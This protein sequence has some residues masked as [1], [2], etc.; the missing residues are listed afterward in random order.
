[1]LRIAAETGT[2]DIVATPHANHTYAFR[3]ELIRERIEELRKLAPEGLKLHT[4]CD[5]H[6]RF[7]NIED[8]LQHP[9]RYTIN[10]RGYLMVEL[11]DSVIPP[12]MGQV[13]ERMLEK[14]IRPVITH[15]ERVP[16]LL[17]DPALLEPWIAQGCSVQITAQSLEGRFG[18]RASDFA[19]QLL[20]RDRVHF[21][22]SDAHDTHDRPPRL[23]RARVLVEKKR[24]KGPAETLFYVNPTAALSGS[25]LERVSQST[26]K[27]GKWLGLFR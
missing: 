11:P 14:G 7:D 3:P 8:A 6:L 21:I 10:G 24:G 19:W 27:S 9:A 12:G 16:A 15:P 13:F 18:S 2:T 26:T 25:P 1:M 5:F 20:S 23:D 17:R 4:G 22:A